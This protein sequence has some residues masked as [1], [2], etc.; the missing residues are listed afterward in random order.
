MRVDQTAFATPTV[1]ALNAT[2]SVKEE[3][4]TQVAIARTEAAPTSRVDGLRVSISDAARQAASTAGAAVPSVASSSGDGEAVAA[5]SAQPASVAQPLS[6]IEGVPWAVGV[7]PPLWHPVQGAA[8]A[9]DLLAPKLAEQNTSQTRTPVESEVARDE[10]RP[11]VAAQIAAQSQLAAVSRTGRDP[12][13]LQRTQE[14]SVKPEAA[15][16][17]SSTLAIQDSR[18]EASLRA[19]RRKAS[20]IYSDE[21]G[22]ASQKAPALSLKV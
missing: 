15:L 6:L 17:R 4:R 10:P 14:A 13:Q 18:N 9:T 2:R 19:E 11:D 1:T 7:G 22:Q 8:G 21:A 5:P 16:V 3:T 20:A 12:L